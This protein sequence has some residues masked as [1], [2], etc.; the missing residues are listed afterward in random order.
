[1][2]IPL[3]NTDLHLKRIHSNPFEGISI[4]YEGYSPKAEF[5]IDTSGCTDIVRN[6]I[7]FDWE[8]KKVG[9][10]DIIQV[11]ASVRNEMSLLEEGYVLGADTK[12]FT[13]SGVK[14]GTVI[15]PFEGLV[16]EY[17]GISPNAVIRYDLSG[18]DDFVKNNVSFSSSNSYYANGDN[19]NITIS[20]ST[21][22]AEENGVVFV[23]EEKA[24]TVSGLPE[25]PDNDENVDYTVIDEQF[26]AM[27]ESEMADDDY[28]TGSSIH[29]RSVL[30][31]VYSDD[32]YVVKEI[33]YTPV[34]KM[35]FNAKDS[36]NSSVKNNHLV[37]WD[38]QMTAEKTGTASGWFITNDD[39]AVGSQVTIN[40]YAV[41]Y[42]Q[43]I[44]VNAD[45]TVNDTEADKNK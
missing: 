31:D 19:A 8:D 43:N 21:S 40:Y 33:K 36:K 26:L 45:G 20:Y 1:M 7:K 25:Y 15:D 13:V 9:N 2:K 38:I 22:K 35:Y 44:A 18:C 14:E 30:T 32:E 41:T 3:R 42:I 39:V 28:Y 6:N 23:Q 4:E 12:D 16:L 27:I 17:E 37:I 24:Y 34:K 5:K 11:K 29:G 10:G